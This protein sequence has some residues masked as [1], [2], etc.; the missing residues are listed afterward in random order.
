MRARTTSLRPKFTVESRLDPDTVM[1]CIRTALDARDGRCRGTAARRCAE[2]FVE[3]SERRF[4]SPHL[5]IQVQETPSGSLLSGRFSP[6][7]EV[8]TMVM[9]VYFLMGFAVV[10][11]SSF[12]YVQW[13]MGTRPWGLAAVPGG[14]LVIA[15]LHIVG[16]VGQR[17]SADQMDWLRERLDELLECADGPIAEAGGGN[18]I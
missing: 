9:F 13:L 8:W 18:A 10:L 6:R 5:S 1:R 17:L 2:L 14:V 3:E 16:M 4:W 11:G 7:P 12:G 15:L